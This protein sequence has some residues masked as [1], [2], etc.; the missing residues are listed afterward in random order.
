MFQGLRRNVGPVPLGA[1]YYAER[2]GQD[3]IQ[4]SLAAAEEAIKAFSAACSAAAVPLRVMREEGDPSSSWLRL[5]GT[6]TSVY[7]GSG[8]GSTMA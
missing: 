3:R 7:S 5:G 8:G 2:L 1:T 6:P 4:H